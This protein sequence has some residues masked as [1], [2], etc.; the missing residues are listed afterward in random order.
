[1]VVR[2]LYFYLYIYIIIFFNN[3]GVQLGCLSYVVITGGAVVAVI[4]GITMG[5]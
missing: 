3:L 4:T 2:Q 5:F 1:M